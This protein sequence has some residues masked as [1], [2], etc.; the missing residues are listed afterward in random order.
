MNKVIKY[1]GSQL[2]LKHVE[3]IADLNSCVD[4]CHNV[5][6]LL[7]ERHRR[8]GSW[9][10]MKGRLLQTAYKTK[11][12]TYNREVSDLFSIYFN[13]LSGFPHRKESNYLLVGFTRH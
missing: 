2:F 9:E 1:R 13:L 8:C 11:P 3:T 4:T 12:I 7:A 10:A 6:G 5:D